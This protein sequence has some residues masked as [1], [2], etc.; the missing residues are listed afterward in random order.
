M[1]HTFHTVPLRLS[2]SGTPWNVSRLSAWML[3][4]LPASSC[5]NRCTRM[6]SRPSGSDEDE[7]DT[8]DEYEDEGDD[9]YEDEDD[10][11]DEG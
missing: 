9:E 7:D 4:Q 6:L 11:E 1:I 5:L 2:L 3:M 10:D 8:E